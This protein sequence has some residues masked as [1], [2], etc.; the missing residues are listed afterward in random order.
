MISNNTGEREREE[1]PKHT[2]ANEHEC[3]WKNRIEMHG[4]ER[5]DEW[6]KDPEDCTGA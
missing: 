1:R 4:D 6:M 5:R 2:V 3:C